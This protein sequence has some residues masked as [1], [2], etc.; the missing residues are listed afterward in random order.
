MRYILGLAA[1]GTALAAA[2]PALAAAPAGIWANPAKSVHVAFTQ[3]GRALCGTVIWA[4]EKAKADA[5]L[6]GTPQLVG[7]QL[8]RNFVEAGPGHWTG[9]VFVPDIGQTLSGTIERINAT[10]L[11][12]EGCLFQGFG[13][14]AQTW[15]RIK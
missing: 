2:S 1:L 4:S 8:F 10:T 15:T 11:R 3:C 12:G 13:C 9:E 14:K 6:G 5:R 7:A